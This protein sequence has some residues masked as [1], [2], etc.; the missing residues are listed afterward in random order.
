MH[1]QEENMAMDFYQRLRREIRAWSESGG[2]LR[3]WLEWI[4]VAPDLFH[5][6][7]R[8]SADP[9]VAGADKIKLTLVIAY[10]ITPLDLLPELFMGPSGFLEDVFLAVYALNAMISHTDISIIRKHWAGKEDV[11]EIIQRVLVR[12]DRLLGSGMIKKLK[13]MLR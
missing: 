4:M 2:R 13:K 11:L 7:L 5:L 3:K 9:E 8:L 12:G 1:K 6:L 10:F